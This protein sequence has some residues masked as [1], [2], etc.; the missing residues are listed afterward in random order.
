MI[1]ARKNVYKSYSSN[2]D[3]SYLTL[4]ITIKEYMGTHLMLINLQERYILNI[5][6]FS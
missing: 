3:E 1:N 4:Y 6:I 2:Y 5:C